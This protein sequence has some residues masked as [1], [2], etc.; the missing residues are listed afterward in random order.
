MGAAQAWH[1]PDSYNPS[2]HTLRRFRWFA[3]FMLAWWG[4]SL[5]V[6][7]AS[8]FALSPGIERIC[9]GAGP[10]KF[11]WMDGTDP[12]VPAAHALDCPLCV[13]VAAPPPAAGAPGAA[14]LPQ[15]PYAGPMPAAPRA[16]RTAATMQARAPPFYYKN[17]SF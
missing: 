2:M 12:A 13:P 15:G 4:A 10:G 3:C 5:G 1:A 11:M 8:P 17:S 6:A 7:A 9:S 14:P 16:A